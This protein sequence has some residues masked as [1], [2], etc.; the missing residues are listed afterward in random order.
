MT[1][2][3]YR[4]KKFVLF[5][6]LFLLTLNACFLNICVARSSQDI[7]KALIL[8]NQNQWSK[9]QSLVQSLK[10]PLLNE[11][12]L[13]QSYTKQGFP[14]NNQQMF[15]GLDRFIRDHPEWPGINALKEKAEALMP[16]SFTPLQVISWYGKDKPLT[17][18][19][20]DRYID[21]LMAAGRL[22][23]ARHYLQ[24]WWRDA[25]LTRDQQKSIY[26]KY[27]AHIDGQTNVQ[28]M[29][30]L[31]YKGQYQNALAI[32]NVLEKGYPDLARARIALSEQQP[33]VEAML[34]KVPVHLQNDPGLLYER[35]RWRRVK[36]LD[37][38]VIDILKRMPQAKDIQNLEAWWTERSILMRRLIEKKEFQAAYNLAA[39]HKQTDPFS[40]SQA[41]WSAGW[42][43]LRFLKQPAKALPHFQKLYANVSTPISKSRGAYWIGLSYTA[44]GQKENAIKWYQEAARYQITFYG[45][46]ASMALSSKD[47]ALKDETPVLTKAQQQKFEQDDLIRAAR[48][49]HKAGMKKMSVRFI[50]AFVDHHNSIQGYSYGA[51]LA[52]EFNYYSDSVKISK[53]AA[54]ESLILIPTSYPN[55]KNYVTDPKMDRA[56]ILSLIRQ[57]SIFDAA[58]RSPAGALGLMQIMPAT[59]AETARKIGISHSQDRLTSDPSHNIKIGS[60]YLNQLLQRYD[61]SYPLAIAAYNA[62]PGRVNRWLNLFGDP[63]KGEVDMT[64]WIEL[65]PIYETRNYVQRVMEGREVYLHILNKK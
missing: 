47:T 41:E 3:T 63:R 60:Y 14:L 7:E 32:S 30:Y 11:I 62:G 29:D 34:R 65:I 31:L 55:F 18:I 35:M 27:A 48:L 54:G 24:L 6:S 17:V 43:A 10:D 22:T 57:E 40:L 33:G 13:W 20:N 64:D 61:G 15:I 9:A 36:N 49:Y 39:S 28:R 50:N 56:L 37:S 52:Q 4:I 58:A 45:Q 16:L 44:L 1:V 46:M 19:G 26:R 42:L 25:M 12:F 5:F 51:K 53:N 59:G 21:A 2:Q 23:E 8:I 38:G